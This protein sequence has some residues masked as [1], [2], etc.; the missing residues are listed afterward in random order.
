MGQTMAGRTPAK[1]EVIPFEP[2]NEFLEK[3]DRIQL[4]KQLIEVSKN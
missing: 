1:Q 2:K 3:G 4:A